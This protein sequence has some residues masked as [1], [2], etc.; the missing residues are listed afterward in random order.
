[1]ASQTAVAHGGMARPAA[2]AYGG[3][4]PALYK[5][6]ISLKMSQKFRKKRKRGLGRRGEESEG[7]E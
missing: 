2:V 6:K 4:F 3:K 5:S 7:V 1:M